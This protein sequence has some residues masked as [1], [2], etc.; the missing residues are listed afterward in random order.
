MALPNPN[1][2]KSNNLEK[3]SSRLQSSLESRLED[4]L[5]SLI[6]LNKM[7]VVLQKKFYDK[8]VLFLDA[9][10]E[11]REVKDTAGGEAGKDSLFDSLKNSLGGFKF[12]DL[13]FAA[14][15]AWATG[16][17][18]YLQIKL[19]PRIMKVI[20]KPFLAF[21]KMLDSL[22]SKILKPFRVA[23]ET[24]KKGIGGINTFFTNI[25]ENVLRVTGSIK[26]TF[27]KITGAIKEGPFAKVFGAIGKFFK[28]IVTPLLPIVKLIARLSGVGTILFAIFDF[29]KGFMAGFKEGGVLEGIKEGIYEIIRG[30]VT[31]PL[32]LLKDLFAWAAG[33]LGFES[34]KETLDSFS[35]TELFNKMVEKVEEIISGIATWFKELFAD[36]KE[37]LGNL[38][39]DTIEWITNFA[40][41]V[42]EK[43]IK[44]V[45]DWVTDKFS[46]VSGSIGSLVGNTI[47]W[48]TNFPTKAYEKY[49]KPVVDWVTD[50]FSTAVDGFASLVGD[51]FDWITNFQTKVYEKY[52][53][54]VVDWAKKLFSSEDEKPED[55]G[56]LSLGDSFSNV[57]DMFDDF[58]IT[59]ITKNILATVG[60]RLN[61]V[62]QLLAEK[63]NS[64]KWLG[65]R[66]SPLLADAGITAGSF[67]GAKNLKRFSADAEGNRVLDESTF[68]AP[69]PD[70]ASLES[71]TRQMDQFKEANA[72]SLSNVTINNNGGNT[73]QNI[74]NRT[75]TSGNP[76]N[77][78]ANQGLL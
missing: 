78:R 19:L 25:Y 58:S 40:S 71:G 32:D 17:D 31:K 76:P 47:D 21:G 55:V 50:K 20:S 26:Q 12:G 1:P 15:A 24:I 67:F 35:F 61:N 70:S 10:L 29:F 72:S 46:T 73:Q 34:F 9:S 43:Y 44:P 69:P 13:L 62:F 33:K 63:I 36:P 11:K 56:K 74:S 77:V 66:L 65:P 48:I 60:E 7:L 42:Y 16:L 53:K 49:I 59:D 22:F 52:I 57:K 28:S 18:D 8:F 54:P 38:V 6:I 64:I 68:E 37:T 23:S 41:K 51:T 27:G 39:G 5:A 45:V 30:F 14:L 75:N 3:P 2:Q 4:K